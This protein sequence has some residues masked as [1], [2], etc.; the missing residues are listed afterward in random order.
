MEWLQPRPGQLQSAGKAPMPSPSAGGCKG[1]A[2]LEA[3]LVHGAG[4]GAWEW[5]QWESAL[6]KAG[7]QYRPIELQP[8]SAGYEVL[9]A[10]AL[11][12]SRKQPGFTGD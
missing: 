4:G 3:V 10:C 9:I 2:P 8:V 12:S 7:I 11:V 5:M 1:N 6:R